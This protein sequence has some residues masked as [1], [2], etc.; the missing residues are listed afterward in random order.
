MADDGLIRHVF[1]GPGTVR[2]S[3]R[4]GTPRVGATRVVVVDAAGTPPAA[5]EPADRPAPSW[6]ETGDVAI[7]V[8]GPGVVPAGIAAEVLRCHLLVIAP[9]TEIAV[10]GDPTVRDLLA[11]KGAPGVPPVDGSVPADR[12]VAANLVADV[13]EEPTVAALALADVLSGLAPL[14][15]AWTLRITGRR[16]ASLRESL[17]LEADSQMECLVS[18]DH[19]RLLAEGPR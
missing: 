1:L 14:A 3:G 12:L 13:A 16:D 15:V 8:L 17:R 18:A 10:D 6:A 5:A 9:S 4:A 2:V 7:G 19:L 11:A